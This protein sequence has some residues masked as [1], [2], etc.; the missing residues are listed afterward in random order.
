MF[1]LRLPTYKM[2]LDDL[3]ALLGMVASRSPTYS[4]ATEQCYWFCSSILSIIRSAFPSSEFHE[5]FGYKKAGKLGSMQ[6][7][8]RGSTTTKEI[9]ADFLG[10]LS[11][12]S[13]AAVGPSSSLPRHPI[14]QPH[15]PIQAPPWPHSQ[16][17][18]SHYPPYGHDSNARTPGQHGFSGAVHYPAFGGYNTFPPA[19]LNQHGQPTTQQSTYAY[20][21][22]RPQAPGTSATQ[23]DTSGPYPPAP[24]GPLMSGDYDLP[25]TADYQ[26]QYNQGRPFV[27]SPGIQ[28]DFDLVGIIYL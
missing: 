12:Q 26:P 6:P 16:Q 13:E 11:G 7:P 9:L 17:Q 14:T 2:S 18:T 22:Q 5:E 3:R 4:L 28:Q 19:A 8:F 1:T 20:A 21:P 25:Q 27:I 23:Q 10:Y 24:T 15:A